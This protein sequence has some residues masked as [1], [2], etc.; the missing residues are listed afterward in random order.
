MTKLLLYFP[1]ELHDALNDSDLEFA[2]RDFL[3]LL[4]KK[5]LAAA[6][7]TAAGFIEEQQEAKFWEQHGQ[8]RRSRKNMNTLMRFIGHCRRPVSH[9]CGATPKPEPPGLQGNWKRALRDQLNDPTG[10]RNPQIVVP[11]SHHSDWSAGDEA[12]V[13]CDPCGD[14][15]PSGPHPRILAVLEDYESHP[16][17]IGD[18][19]PW[20]CFEWARQ[21]SPGARG[22]YPC[23]L[24]RPPSL[25]GVP[26]EQLLER[27]KGARK[28]GW[29]VDGRCFFIPP[30]DFDPLSVGR[31]QWRKGHVFKHE[32][33]AGGR[34]SG[35]IDYRGQI[36]IWHGETAGHEGERHWDVQVNSGHERISHDGRRL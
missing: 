25:D 30:D 35:P 11:K 9:V 6:G 31:L 2:I 24:P 21:P 32:N 8:E 20:R 4:G 26:I 10:W 5:E 33:A 13:H 1:W 27:L 29:E 14:Q 15:P 17:A 16:F 22:A 12:N 19:D 3:R 23:R 18:A 36:W 34:G 28:R 7:F